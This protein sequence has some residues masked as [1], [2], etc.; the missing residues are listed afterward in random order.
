MKSSIQITRFMVLDGD[1]IERLIA[2]LTGVLKPSFVN[3]NPHFTL[4]SI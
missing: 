2:M 1:L 3:E 4:I